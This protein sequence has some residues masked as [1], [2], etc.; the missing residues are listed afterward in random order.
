MVEENIHS[1]IV[2]CLGYITFVI[3][4]KLRLYHLLIPFIGLSAC[5]QEI[6]TDRPIATLDLPMENDIVY[7]DDDLRLVASF[8][9]N[10]G[11]LQYKLVLGGLDELNG[12]VAD[13]TFS[14]I[15][16][17]AIPDE[18]KTYYLDQIIELNENVYNAHYR[19]VVSCIDV[20]GNESI[21]DTVDFQIKN[22]ADQEP[23]V[24][25]VTGPT[26]GDTLGIGQGFLVLGDVSDAQ[27]LTY[28]EI[29]IG[30][31]DF[32]DTIRFTTF[33][34]VSNNIVDYDDFTWWHQVDSSW[35]QG[36]Y[37][38]Y[39][40]AWDQSVGVTHSIPFYVSY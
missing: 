38:I 6:D 22:S 21:K 4:M 16:V 7:S 23:P 35:V 31:S 20:E 29:F 3:N 11:L 28:T 14:L 5:K 30:P 33:P 39:Y 18:K 32:S 34:W 27:D 8:S 17:D 1:K 10:T 25:N 26:E 36:N 9:D 13:S 2:S 19:V 40:T 24:F 37:H 15:Y 12:I